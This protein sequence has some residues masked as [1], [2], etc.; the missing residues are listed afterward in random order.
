MGNLCGSSS[1]DDAPP[2]RPTQPTS[3]TPAPA[4]KPQ[5]KPK[6]V[7]KSQAPGRTLGSGD[8]SQSAS[9]P[10][11][12][13]ARAAEVSPGPEARTCQTVTRTP[14]RVDS[15]LTLFY[16]LQERAAKLQ[17]APKGALAQKLEAQRR[18]TQSET[19]SAA[20]EQNRGF[21]QADEAAQTRAW[22]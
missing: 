18:Q 7:A 17:S 12:A 2:P 14:F 1:K 22:K 5:P 11:T 4:P 16:V 13:A 3:S 9:D 19:L 21:R 20:S 10:R 6:P 15:L 8:S